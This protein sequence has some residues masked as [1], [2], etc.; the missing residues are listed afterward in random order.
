MNYIVILYINLN[1]VV[2]ECFGVNLFAQVCYVPT[3]EGGMVVK[4]LLSKPRV[5]VREATL[6]IK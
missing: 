3:L 2:S 5:Y 1:F 6:S 4:L